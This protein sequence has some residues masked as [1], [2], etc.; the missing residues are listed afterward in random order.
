[1]Q[2]Y[3]GVRG[4]PKDKATIEHLNFDGP[5]YWGGGLDADDI[6][7][8]CG[9]CNS[10]RGTKALEVWFRSTYCIARN[11]NAE[12]VAAPVKAYLKRRAAKLIVAPSST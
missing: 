10:S 4:C 1:M 3:P 6:V 11:I 8:C 5:L 2:D 9:S 12:T 7:I